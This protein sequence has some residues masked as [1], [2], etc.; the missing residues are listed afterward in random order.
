MMGLLKIA[1]KFW[2]R[3]VVRVAIERYGQPSA[4]YLELVK[5]IGRTHDGR[6]FLGMDWK[7]PTYSSEP[8][9]VTLKFADMTPP[10]V[11]YPGATPVPL[12]EPADFTQLFACLEACEELVA[13]PTE[14]P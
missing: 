5:G 1:S 6:I 10:L 11:P 2:R 14:A 7:A 9:E 8:I 3:A 13:K 12:Y 4:R